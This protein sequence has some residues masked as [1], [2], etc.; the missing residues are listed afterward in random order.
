MG[1]VVGN[2]Q[3]I[4][5][6]AHTYDEA[7]ADFGTAPTVLVIEN[8]D[9][10]VVYIPMSEV[11]LNFGPDDQLTMYL[12]TPLSDGFARPAKY[13]KPQAFEVGQA[14]GIAYRG[15]NGEF[16]VLETKITGIM[17]DKHFV[18]NPLAVEGNSNHLLLGS[19]DSGGGVFVNGGYIGVNVQASIYWFDRRA[20]FV[21]YPPHILPPG[22][23]G[24]V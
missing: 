23:I 7:F 12:K 11:E 13:A 17:G 2:M 18:S 1:T 21:P 10:T 22:P 9:G 14:V 3:T 20:Y 24:S 19:G 8:K 5:T 6:A 4:A 15:K 16:Q